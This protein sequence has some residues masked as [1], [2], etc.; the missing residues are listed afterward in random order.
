MVSSSTPNSRT[1]QVVYG[2]VVGNVEYSLSQKT[3]YGDYEV[4]GQQE[5]G[6][7]AFGYNVQIGSDATP[8]FILDVCSNFSHFSTLICNLDHQQ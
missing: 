1:L 2:C 6:L 8:T 3:T 5:T 7:A 4:I